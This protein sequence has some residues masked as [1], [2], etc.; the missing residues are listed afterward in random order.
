MMFDVYIVG[1][2]LGVCLRVFPVVGKSSE[3]IR[4]RA[5]TAPKQDSFQDCITGHFW[6]GSRLHVRTW[7]VSRPDVEVSAPFFLKDVE[8][9]SGRINHTSG[10]MSF[11][12]DFCVRTNFRPEVWGITSGR[13]GF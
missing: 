6:P 7:R 3:C 1:A 12:P 8:C 4:G 2:L 9:T 10:R 5:E 11:C 13:I